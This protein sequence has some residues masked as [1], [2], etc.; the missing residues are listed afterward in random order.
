[1]P[2]VGTGSATDCDSL[3]AASLVALPWASIEEVLGGLED[4]S[5]GAPRRE[6]VRLAVLGGFAADRVAFATVAG[7]E[8]AL[9]RLLA[10]KSLERVAFC[11]SEAG[12]G[13]PRAIETRL[14]EDDGAWKLFGTKSFVT[15][16]EH[17]EWYVVIASAGEHGD[18]KDLR[19]ALVRRGAPGAS[20]TPRAP[21]PFA[22]ELPHGALQLDGAPVTELLEGDGFERYAKPFRTVEDTHVTLAIV[23][24]G[25]AEARRWLWPEEALTT[26]LRELFALAHEDAAAKE[27]H[28]ALDAALTGARAALDAL[29]WPSAPAE[30][31]GR[32]LRD[33]PLL[34]VASRVR[35]LRADRARS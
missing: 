10:P 20:V 35:Q 17:A 11:L 34:D 18:R 8:A 29:P 4:A 5:M 30:I 24:Y 26:S 3:L 7:Y 9:V 13:H 16:A 25:L 1:M 14:V 22:P 21:L 23:A 28:R 32:W 19:A 2:D 33:R 15:L 12:G 6:P 27:T 31:A